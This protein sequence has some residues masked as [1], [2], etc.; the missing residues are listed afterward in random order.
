VISSIGRGYHPCTP[1]KYVTC[2][3]EGRGRCRGLGLGADEPVE[4][5]GR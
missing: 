5:V 2:E 1:Y 3:K 4:S